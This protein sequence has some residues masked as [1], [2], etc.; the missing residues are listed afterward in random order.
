MKR[1]S[2]EKRKVESQPDQEP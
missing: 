2:Y 1:R